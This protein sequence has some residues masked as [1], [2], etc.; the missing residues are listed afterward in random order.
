VSSR[1]EGPLQAA[2]SAE[3][4][5]SLVHTARRLRDALDALHKFDAEV[6]AGNRLANAGIRDRLLDRSA[7]LFLG[8]VVQRETL[9]LFDMEYLRKEYNLP[10]DVWLRLGATRRG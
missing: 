4:A 8:Y 5:A 1:F 3:A 9:G 6:R 2:L 10:Q 7:D